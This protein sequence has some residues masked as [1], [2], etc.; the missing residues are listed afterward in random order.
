MAGGDQV[1][2][3]QCALVNPC[4]LFPA[5]CF[6]K[7]CTNGGGPQE[8]LEKAGGLGAASR[9]LVPW[10]EGGRRGLGGWVGEAGH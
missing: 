10:G 3:T 8:E 4:W 9:L 1:Y 5:A 2:H 6:V 7:K